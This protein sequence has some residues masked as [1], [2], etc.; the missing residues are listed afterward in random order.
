MAG[1]MVDIASCSTSRRWKHTSR[2]Q[3][4]S[5]RYLD[6]RMSFSKPACTPPYTLVSD[7][8]A[9]STPLELFVHG[10][11]PESAADMLCKHPAP[12]SESPH[13]LQSR[14]LQFGGA[15]AVSVCCSRNDA[16]VGASAAVCCC[17][18]GLLAAH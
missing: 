17:P 4:E 11:R 5:A 13:L 6:V 14:N 16:R 12:T 1:D 9:V 7:G 2:R 18:E 3:I 15:S 10:G 8:R